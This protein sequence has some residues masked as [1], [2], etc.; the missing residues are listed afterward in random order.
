MGLLGYK[1]CLAVP[2]L[3][4]KPEVMCDFKYHSYVL[5]YVG[6]IMVI[7]HHARPVLDLINRSKYMKLNKS[8]VRDPDLYLGAQIRKM[9]M[10]NEILT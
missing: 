10:P 9:K 5:C 8:S 3:W 6:D 2:D 1:S 4:T 7:H